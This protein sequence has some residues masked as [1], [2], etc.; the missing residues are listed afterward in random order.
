MIA[1]CKKC[2][3]KQDVDISSVKGK[4]VRYNCNKCDTQNLFVIPSKVKKEQLDKGKIKTDGLSLKTKITLIIVALVVI[5]ISAVGYISSDRGAKALA[6]LARHNLQL[7]TGQKATEYNAIFNRLQE[8]IEGIALFAEQTFARPSLGEGLNFAVLMPWTGSGYGTEQMK[9]TFASDINAL[10]EVNLVLKGI[11][12][13]NPYIDLGYM[14]TTNEVMILN[15]ES[16]VDVIASRKEYIPSKRSWFTDAA[17]AKK[18]IWTAPYVDVVTKK[19]IVSCATPVYGANKQLL[20][21]VGFD[22]SLDTIQ[23][24]IISLN[25]GHNSQ[26]F[27]IGNKGNLLAKPNMGEV[28]ADWNEA[29]KTDNLLETPNPGLKAIVTR[30]LNKENGVATYSE[31]GE[32]EIV[33]F[34]SLPAIGASVGITVTESIVMKPATDIQKLIISVWGVVVVISILIGY[35]IGSGI[36]RPI[37]EIIGKANLISQGKTDL[38]L[39]STNRKDEIGV[40]VESFNRLISSLKIAMSIDD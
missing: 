15:D 40:L 38:D 23:K 21:V 13:N 37:N 22:V 14:A 4:V 34:A 35:L 2:K 33:A 29:V 3:A 10:R 26:A 18:T 11:V 7:I 8:E 32:T 36:T 6:D 19:L 9:T 31:N 28:D 30:M 12:E 5:S 25:I 24:D 27:L 1:V 20:G 39:M 17:E 16:T